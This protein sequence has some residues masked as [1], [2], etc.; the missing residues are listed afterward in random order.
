MKSHKKSRRNK[1]YTKNKNNNK[2]KYLSKKNTINYLKGGAS[3]KP[4]SSASSNPST[5]HFPPS[6]TQPSST[7]PGLSFLAHGEKIN[8]SFIVPNGYKILYFAKSGK[9]LT[10]I[11]QIKNYYQHTTNDT[12][13]HIYKEGEI[14]SDTNLIIDPVIA[15]TFL[16]N[17]MGVLPSLFDFYKDS[18]KP[19]FLKPLSDKALPIFNDLSN[20]QDLDLDKYKKYYEIFK[21]LLQ[22]YVDEGDDNN[23]IMQQ[24][25][26]PISIGTLKN[27]EKLTMPERKQFSTE[28]QEHA[29]NINIQINKA[30]E[31]LVRDKLKEN[32]T[33][34]EFLRLLL[35]NTN[36]FLPP[37][38]TNVSSILNMLNPGEYKFYNCRNLNEDVKKSMNNGNI[39]TVSRALSIQ[40]PKKPKENIHTTREHLKYFGG[41]NGKLCVITRFNHLFLRKVAKLIETNSQGI[42]ALSNL[43]N[44]INFFVVGAKICKLINRENTFIG[45]TQKSLGY[46]Q[47]NIKLN[48]KGIEIDLY[49]PLREIID[50]KTK[51]PQE[52]VKRLS[53]SFITQELGLIENQNPQ[54]EE[55]PDEIKIVNEI[56][57]FQTDY[58]EV[59]NNLFILVAEIVM[60][61]KENRGI[62]NTKIPG[63]NYNFDELLII[64]KGDINTFEDLL[65]KIK[66]N[67][68]HITKTDKNTN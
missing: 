51:S 22:K 41:V 36:F 19:K 31:L 13:T 49:I 34:E 18:T 28:Y 11:D 30:C 15:N 65:K 44:L 40:S 38:T 21:L 48:Y 35:I 56:I 55:R 66:I 5:F 10:V 14:I 1:N 29:V 32:T 12:Y 54:K 53:S 68:L 67:D 58:I 33:L 50:P 37:T 52:L 20:L 62:L 7:Q 47:E 39:S 6:S 64:P 42:P 9:P 4:S 24:V 43:S 60:K 26:K 17:Y 61:V 25:Y 2:N 16:I 45:I 8:Q 27:L 59:F 46:T 23:T 63:F 57:T 3:K